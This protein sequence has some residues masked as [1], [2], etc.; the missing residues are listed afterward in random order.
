VRA[1]ILKGRQQGCSTYVGGR[2]ADQVVPQFIT[3]LEAEQ[4]G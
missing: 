1:L 3:P 4:R 2:L